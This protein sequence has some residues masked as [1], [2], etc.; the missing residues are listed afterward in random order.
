M[1][2]ARWAANGESMNLGIRKVVPAA[3]MS[4]FIVCSSALAGPA[5]A[6]ADDGQPV[7]VDDEAATCS[8][9]FTSL[10]VRE[11][12]LRISAELQL[13][14]AN[15]SGPS[16]WELT[17]SAVE[18]DSCEIRLRDSNSSTS[19]VLGQDSDRL[20]IASTVTRL[21][22]IIDGIP[23]PPL[24]PEVVE[25]EVVEE[26]VV[27]EEVVAEEVEA[28]ETMEEIDANLDEPAAI[29]M[30]MRAETQPESQSLEQLQGLSLE[31]DSARETAP[32]G[33]TGL[34]DLV[35]VH[36]PPSILL[37]A[38]GGPMWIPS[39]NA[40]L[41]IVRAQTSWQPS[42]RIKFDLAGR[43]PTGSAFIETHQHQF[44]YQPWS[45]DLTA[46][47]KH[48]ISDKWSIQGGGGARWTWAKITAGDRTQDSLTNTNGT[49]PTEN[50]NEG[51]N[52]GAD[53]G[54][55]TDPNRTEAERTE[56]ERAE[57]NRAESRD[58]R[59]DEPP[60]RII[61][62]PGI[63]AHNALSSWSMVARTGVSYS[64]NRT[65]ALGLDL[66]GAASVV[67][68]E[69]YENQ[70]VILDL[71]RLEFALLLGLEARF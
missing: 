55:D 61:G 46:S 62:G 68:R 24:Q 22:W 28:L 13:S 71:G 51:S 69:I 26:E 1:Y 27:E 11:L 43:L 60:R 6:L 63:S 54:I 37:E 59:F 10:F 31:L 33:S 14:T 20:E 50:T 36:S 16:H 67:K 41:M 48:Q 12:G 34:V 25:E 57:A 15:G 58:S 8:S 52:G 47:F 17:L 3:L 18:D 53:P 45:G 4:V 42:P 29:E 40:T 19:F 66:S 30:Q 2:V 44:S 9:E 49:E 64:L 7:R 38:R 35:E 39:S 5:D 70:R 56:A 23:E 21:A 32:D 65:F